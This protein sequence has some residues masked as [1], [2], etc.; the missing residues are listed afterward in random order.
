VSET[1]L[2]AGSHRI[3]A[4]RFVIASGSR[5]LVPPIPG[6]DAVPHHTNET[7]FGLRDRPEHLL[8]V[9]GGPIGMEM[10]QAHRRLGSRVTVLEG[11]AALGKDDPEAAALVLERLRAEGIEI[12]EG[13]QVSQ[14]SG[15][16]GAIRVETGDGQVFDGSHILVAVGRQPNVDTLNL[17]AAHVG[18]D[19]KGVTTDKGMRTTNRRVYAIG[20]VT[21]GLQ[22]TH[23]A[24]YQA[25]VIIRPMLFGL[26]AKARADH[27]PWTTY[28]DPELAQVGLTE[29]EARRQHGDKLFVARAEFADNDRAIATGQDHGFAKVM[30]VKGRPVGATIVGP[31]A[32][33]LIQTWALAIASGLKMSAIAGMVAPYPTLGEI[34]K[35]AAGAYFSPRLFESSL[36]KRIVRFVQRLP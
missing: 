35:R 30:I 18:H 3:A 26:P 36:V 34:N 1:E 6:L 10:A 32:G 22:F 29:A 8:I 15:S 28:T 17:D 20:D 13:A 11:A 33:E 25:G 2:E 5:P 24:G 21:G 23:L 16:E 31:Q 19:G 14:V 12:A 7:I 4:R 9:G 27:V